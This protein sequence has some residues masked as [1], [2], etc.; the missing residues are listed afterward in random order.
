MQNPS[1]S[2][3]EPDRTAEFSG[4]FIIISSPAETTG[5]LFVVI[6]LK[7]PYLSFFPISSTVSKKT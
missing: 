5:G 7:G 4:K 1:E 3:Q 6:T 2:W